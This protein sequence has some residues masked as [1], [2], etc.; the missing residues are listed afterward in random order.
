MT[1]ITLVFPRMEDMDLACASRARAYPHA[2]YCPMS[3]H[4]A[5]EGKDQH[6]PILDPD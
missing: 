6:Q 2:R 4:D 3:K 5:Q 1:I